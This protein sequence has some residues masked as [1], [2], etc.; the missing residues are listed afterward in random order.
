MGL[1][2]KTDAAV[3]VS[4][5]ISQNGSVSNVSVAG[6]SGVSTLDHLAQRAI[7]LAAPF[8]KIPIGFTENKLDITYTLHYVK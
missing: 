1:T 3:V 8:G 6:S 7:Q 4:F 2:E 5:T